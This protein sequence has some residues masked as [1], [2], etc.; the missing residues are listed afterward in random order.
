MPSW[1]EITKEELDAELALADNNPAN[2]DYD[3]ARPISVIEIEG[4]LDVTWPSPSTRRVMQFRLFSEDVWC[5]RRLPDGRWRKFTPVSQSWRIPQVASAV[6]EPRVLNAQD[7]SQ[8][9]FNLAPENAYIMLVFRTDNGIWA[10][11]QGSGGAFYAQY[12]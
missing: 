12:S 10:L 7:G 2:S 11:G 3:N 1:S 6:A 8:P 9:L 4:S 5:R